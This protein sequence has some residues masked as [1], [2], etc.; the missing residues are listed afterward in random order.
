MLIVYRIKWFSTALFCLKSLHPF[1]CFRSCSNIPT[2]EAA[3]VLLC[4]WA[5]TMKFAL[6]Q[7]FSTCLAAARFVSSLGTRAT[8]TTWTCCGW[9]VWKTWTRCLS[10][11]GTSSNP[12]TMTPKGRKPSLQ[13][14][15]QT[16]CEHR[17]LLILNYSY[18][19]GSMLKV[20]TSLFCCKT[21]R[22]FIMY[23]YLTTVKGVHCTLQ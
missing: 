1:M 20:N 2:T 10:P 18:T 15:F 17:S 8:A 5:C 16:G 9:T 11:T 4:F 22:S 6:K 12:L 14:V 13:V 23:F 21:S 3:I 19:R 7:S